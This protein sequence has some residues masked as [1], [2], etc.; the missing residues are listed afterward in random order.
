M[1]YWIVWN[2]MIEPVADFRF[3]IEGADFEAVCRAAGFAEVPTPFV[4]TTR[5]IHKDG[6]PLE[7]KRPSRVLPLLRQDALRAARQGD[8]GEERLARRRDRARDVGDARRCQ[9]RARGDDVRAN[10]IAALF[11]HL[12]RKKSRG[13]ERASSLGAAAAR[14]GSSPLALVGD[15]V[16]GVCRRALGESR[17][18]RVA[19]VTF[20]ARCHDA[21][22]GSS[23]KSTA[24]RATRLRPRKPTRPR[25]PPKALGT[26]RRVAVMATAAAMANRPTTAATTATAAELGK[27]ATE[28]PSL[29]RGRDKKAARRRACDDGELNPN[30]PTPCW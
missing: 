26:A 6:L 3:R 20:P 13:R 9:P 10:S 7:W 22:G 28:P 23:R 16:V 17:G 5:C 12:S 29:Q 14:R 19:G 25:P 4:M 24:T 15:A 30:P 11:V 21:I 18:R 2:R 27:R 1:L 8:Q